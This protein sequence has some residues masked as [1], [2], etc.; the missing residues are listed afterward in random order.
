MLSADKNRTT[1]RLVKSR[2]CLQVL[3][4]INRYTHTR[5]HGA[6]LTQSVILRSYPNV[7]C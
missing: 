1:H 6:T 7:S 4:W 5:T 3:V 2:E